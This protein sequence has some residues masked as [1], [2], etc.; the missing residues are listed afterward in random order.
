M[1]APQDSAAQF[2]APLTL[3][4]DPDAQYIQEDD[5]FSLEAPTKRTS[6]PDWTRNE[7]SYSR[8]FFP[9]LLVLSLL[10]HY[11]VE[12]PTIAYY[13]SPPRL[14]WQVEWCMRRRTKGRTHAR[15]DPPVV[16]TTVAVHSGG[17]GASTLAV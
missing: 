14:W 10:A 12:V 3:R 13:W 11:G 6:N 2:S 16:L 4:L 17:S 5:D 15:Q 8:A 1:A 7:E 9:T